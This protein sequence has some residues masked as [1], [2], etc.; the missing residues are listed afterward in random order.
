VTPFRWTGSAIPTDFNLAY[1]GFIE[2]P[3][4]SPSVLGGNPV[5]CFDGNFFWDS[6]GSSLIDLNPSQSLGAQ[7]V[8]NAINL[9]K[10]E[11][12]IVWVKFVAAPTPIQWDE[13]GQKWDQAGAVWS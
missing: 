5:P 8:Y 6:P 12:T 2:C 4:P 1:Q 11:G 10:C 9:A 7:V 13:A 3:L